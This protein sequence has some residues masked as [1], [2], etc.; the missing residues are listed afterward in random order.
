MK[1]DSCQNCKLSVDGVYYYCTCQEVEIDKD[2]AII[3]CEDYEPYESEG[4]SE[5]EE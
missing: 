2:A 1:C 5:V 4:E 3:N